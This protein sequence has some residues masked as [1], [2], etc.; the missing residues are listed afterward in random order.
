MP[1]EDLRG[2]E[3]MIG[4]PREAALDETRSVDPKAEGVQIV[5]HE[6]GKIARAPKALGSGQLSG[7]KAWPDEGLFRSKTVK[8]APRSVASRRLLMGES[9]GYGR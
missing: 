2:C 3:R 6:S 8:E 5:P 1:A 7:R 4:L 9:C